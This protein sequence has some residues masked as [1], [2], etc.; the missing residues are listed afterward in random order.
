MR[1]IKFRARGAIVI[2]WIYGYFI[3]EKGQCFIENDGGRY[4]VR[5]DS[6]CQFTGLKDKNGKEIYSGDL[7]RQHGTLYEILPCVGGFECQIWKEFKQGGAEKGSVYIF[8]CLLDTSCEIIGNIYENP[9]LL[10]SRTE[11]KL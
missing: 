2:C 11:P 8:S 1:E 6:I 3:Q 9:E 7:I 4:S 10:K 5:A